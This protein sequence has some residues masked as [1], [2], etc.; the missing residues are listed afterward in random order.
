M[1]LSENQLD[2]GKIPRILG[3]YASAQEALILLFWA[4]WLVIPH[5]KVFLHKKTTILPKADQRPFFALNIYVHR[6]LVG[7]EIKTMVS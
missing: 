4:C 1:T 6:L 3:S 2:S 7:F 5:S